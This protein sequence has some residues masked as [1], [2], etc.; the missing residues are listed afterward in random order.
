MNSSGICSLQ[1]KTCNKLY[2]GQTGGLF[3]IRHR[4]HVRYTKTNNPL[5]A[6][7]LHILNNRH[8]Y[9]S[10]EH[11]MQLLKSCEKGKLMN[12]WDS[13]D[14]QVLQQ[15]NLLIDEHKTN[16]P[17]P[18]YALASITKHVT[19]LDKKSDSVRTGQARQ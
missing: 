5:S 1:Y 7:A 2:V 6:Y 16:E 3:E 15:Q 18:L 8:E 13:F 19:Q 14:M 4:E 11:T 12:C 9:D 10:P 17:N